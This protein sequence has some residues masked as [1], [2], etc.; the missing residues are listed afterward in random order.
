MHK[1]S[2]GPPSNPHPHDAR[3][4]FGRST[5]TCETWQIP[6]TPKKS[7]YDGCAAAFS[8]IIRVVD[9]ATARQL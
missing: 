7:A 6:V 8:C 2:I 9:L 5:I 1:A 3:P 4:S